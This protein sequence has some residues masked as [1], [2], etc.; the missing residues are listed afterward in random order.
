MELWVSTQRARPWQ[1]L[2]RVITGRA[3]PTLRWKAHGLVNQ[4]GAC[5][6]PRGR[7][8]KGFSPWSGVS[9]IDRGSPGA[10]PH[11][12]T[13]GHLRPAWD[14]RRTCF[15]Y[16]TRSV[17]SFS[18]PGSVGGRRRFL[19]LTL[20]VSVNHRGR[21]SQGVPPHLAVSRPGPRARQDA[22]R[23]DHRQA[24]GERPGG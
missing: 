3:S 8:G 7:A 13:G 14:S 4:Q 6:S 18:A 2:A 19:S 23:G 24:P 21:R 16:L 20:P 10:A 1:R 11:A 12:A 22:T 17:S 9:A 15:A 5:Q